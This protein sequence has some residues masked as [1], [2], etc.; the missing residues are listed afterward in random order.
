MTSSPSRGAGIAKLTIAGSMSGIPVCAHTTVCLL[1]FAA[2]ALLITA[3][4]M[5]DEAGFAL[6]A[7]VLVWHGLRTRGQAALAGA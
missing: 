5:T 3:L 2:A 4:P 7:A 6:A 1:A